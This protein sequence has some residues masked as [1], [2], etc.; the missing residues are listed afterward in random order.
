VFILLLCDVYIFR[1]T[2]NC[3]LMFIMRIRLICATIK[4][5]YLLTY[6]HKPYIAKTR[7]PWLLCR[8]WLYEWIWCSCFQK[9]GVLCEM[10]CNELMTAIQGH[11]RSPILVPIESPYATS[12]YW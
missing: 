12:Y 8:H 3:R 6:L 10:T 4:F 1:I 2:T 11:S 5:T 7:L 9:A